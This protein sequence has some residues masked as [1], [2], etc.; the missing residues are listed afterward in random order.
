MAEK[1]GV[2]KRFSKVEILNDA[3]RSASSIYSLDL[4][5]DDDGVVELSQSSE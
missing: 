1:E 3:V 4:I 2:S 5:S